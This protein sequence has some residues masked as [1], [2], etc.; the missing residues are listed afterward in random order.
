MD[1]LIIGLHID[2][3]QPMSVE[4]VESDP[5]DSGGFAV[6]VNGRMTIVES[7]CFPPGTDLRTRR[8]LNTNTFVFDINTL[9]DSPQLKWFPVVKN[10]DQRRA[11]QFERLLGQLADHHEVSWVIVPREGEQ[12]R[13]IPIKTPADLET[14]AELLRSVLVA[15]GVLGSR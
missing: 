7:F 1:P 4:V 8:F 2:Q 11:I 14:R 3:G 10:V 13:F 6:R 12:S 15:R 9:I 5:T